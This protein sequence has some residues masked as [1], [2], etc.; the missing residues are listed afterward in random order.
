VLLSS[1]NPDEAATCDSVLVLN[2][3][4]KA[5]RRTACGGQA[6]WRRDAPSSR[7]P[8]TA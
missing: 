8:R 4:K 1:S 5:H 2:A 3:G 6:P 7:N